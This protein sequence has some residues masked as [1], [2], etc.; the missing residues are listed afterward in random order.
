M[1]SDGFEFHSLKAV[2]FFVRATIRCPLWRFYP[3]DQVFAVLHDR[4]GN[5][6]VVLLFAAFVF[7][8]QCQPMKSNKNRIGDYVVKPFQYVSTTYS[9][10]GTRA[11]PPC[12][13]AHPP[14]QKDLLRI[15]APEHLKPNRRTTPEFGQR[16][17]HR[18]LH[19]RHFWILSK[20]RCVQGE[21]VRGQI[22]SVNSKARIWNQAARTIKRCYKCKANVH[23]EQA[24]CFS[25]PCRTCHINTKHEFI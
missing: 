9:R 13:P 16:A 5:F 23:Q 1:K 6:V 18:P 3:F 19:T 22:H 8:R 7:F 21:Q 24:S 17:R 10:R 11:Q 14:E 4:V 25:D 20:D 2:A 15:K 12:H